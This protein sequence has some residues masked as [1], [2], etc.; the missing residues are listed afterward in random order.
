MPAHLT[1]SNYC[2]GDVSI[3]YDGFFLRTAS[4]DVPSEGKS[5]FALE[6][7]DVR[8]D[9]DNPTWTYTLEEGKCT[10]SLALQTARK[11]GIPEPILERAKALGAAFDELCRGG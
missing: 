4:F 8:S 5:A 2:I 6:M 9:R 7:D 3:R 10:D 11:Y 1:I